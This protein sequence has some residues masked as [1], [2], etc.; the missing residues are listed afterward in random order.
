M[1]DLEL[2]RKIKK[3]DQKAFDV[4]FY[5]YHKQLCHFAYYYL[6]DKELVEEIVSDV[7]LKV[8]IKKDVI[9][10][11]GNLKSYLYSITKNLAIDHLAKNKIGFSELTPQNSQEHHTK[12][13]PEKVLLFKELNSRINGLIGD[14]PSQCRMVFILNRKDGLKYREIAELM[15]ISVKTVE[16][17]MGKALKVLKNSLTYILFL[18]SLFL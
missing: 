2:I 16:N 15:N 12:N 9:E 10:I 4:L 3:G 13:N 14:L 18:G 1:E 11:K 5:K 7:F 6:S 17:H 8:W